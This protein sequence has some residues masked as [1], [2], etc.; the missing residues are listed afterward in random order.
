MQLIGSPFAGSITAMAQS[1]LARV[2]AKGIFAHVQSAG[3]GGYGVGTVNIVT[4]VGT[5]ASAFTNH[6]MTKLGKE[7]S[8]VEAGVLASSVRE[9][10]AK[11]S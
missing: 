7:R 9:Q 8:R 11:V 6:L 3:M 10:S 2:V 4:R 1:K 5:M